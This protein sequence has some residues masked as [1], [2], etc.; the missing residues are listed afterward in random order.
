[1]AAFIT[2]KDKGWKRILREVQAANG[3]YVKVGVLQSAPPEENGMSMAK[4]ATINE[5]GAPSVGI[6]SRPFMR[7][8]MARISNQIKNAFKSEYSKIL[9]GKTKAVMSLKRIGTFVQKEIKREFTQGKFAPNRPSTIAKYASRIAA[10]K[11]KQKGVKNKSFNSA[12]MAKRP[13]IDTRRLSRSINY[14]VK[15]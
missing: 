15:S 6:P 2:D 1:M 10:G 14:E 12:V 13:L 4:V 7:Q 5:Y 3:A 9:A 11:A 8:T